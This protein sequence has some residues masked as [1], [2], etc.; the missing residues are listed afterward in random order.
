MQQKDG[1]ISP[2]KERILQYVDFI[3]IS[4]RHFYKMTGISHGSLDNPS[5]MTEDLLMKFFVAYPNVSTEWII[6]GVGDMEKKEGK[7]YEKVDVVEEP[8]TP[9]QSRSNDAC[10]NCDRLEKMVDAQEK[11]ISHLS[12]E[13]EE[14]RGRIGGHD[15]AS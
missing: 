13:L 10:R 15:K 11:L 4:K 3:G 12:H 1:K 7:D 8:M 2:F 5:S 9:Y 14:L 6:W